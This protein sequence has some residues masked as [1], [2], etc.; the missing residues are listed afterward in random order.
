M[1]LER[2]MSSD[3]APTPFAI[4]DRSIAP[5]TAEILTIPVSQQVTGL[6]SSLALK[7]IHGAKRGPCVFVSAGIH[8]DEIV[9]AAIVQRLLD[10]LMPE[11]LSFWRPRL[12]STASPRTAAIC[13]TGAISIAA[14]RGTKAAASPRSWRIVS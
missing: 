5:G 10:H 9:G 7:V 8:G 11:T 1:P 4:H 13:P 12:I 6:D 3:D 14:F 2:C